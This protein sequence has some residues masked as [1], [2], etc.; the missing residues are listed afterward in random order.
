IMLGMRSAPEP[1]NNLT[2]DNKTTQ[3]EDKSTAAPTTESQKQKTN[4]D[5]LP[6][7]TEPSVPVK[8]KPL[9]PP[10]VDNVD[11]AWIDLKKHVDP[12]KHRVRGFWHV[13]GNALVS[14]EESST[15]LQLPFEPGDEYELRLIAERPAAVTTLHLVLPLPGSQVSVAF[16]APGSVTTFEMIDKKL[17]INNLTT[18][19]KS[20]MPPGQPCQIFCK[21]RKESIKISVGDTDIIHWQDNFARLSVPTSMWTPNPRAIAVGSSR[22]AIRFTAL[23]VKPLTGPGTMLHGMPDENGDNSTKQKA[24]KER[25]AGTEWLNSKNE[26]F[27]WDGNGKFFHKGVSRG[28]QTIGDKA[29]RLIHD[30]K[31]AEYD[32]LRFDRELTKFQQTNKTG[33]VITNIADGVRLP[34]GDWLD[35]RII[36]TVEGKD[37]L[38]FKQ[39]T[40]RWESIAGKPPAKIKINGTELTWPKTYSIRFPATHAL[41]GKPMDFSKVKFAKIRGKGNVSLEAGSDF[42]ALTFDNLQQTSPELIEISLNLRLGDKPT[43]PISEIGRLI[44]HTDFIND[45]AVS[46]GGQHVASTSK[47]NSVRFWRLDLSKEVWRIQSL[48][49]AMPQAIQFINSKEIIYGSSENKLLIAS[50]ETAKVGLNW[51]ILSPPGDCMLPVAGGRRLLFSTERKVYS[52][53]LQPEIKE[54]KSMA[55]ALFELHKDSKKHAWIVAFSENGERA[56]STGEDETIRIWDTQ[57][58]KELFRLKKTTIAKTGL[59]SPAGDLLATADR[60]SP[61]ADLWDAASGRALRRSAFFVSGSLGALAFSPDGKRLVSGH[62][63]G[64]IRVWNVADLSEI[65]RIK[66]QYGGVRQIRF[67]PDGK[68]IITTSSDKTIRVWSLPD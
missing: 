53:D 3:R 55:K 62:G 65:A 33:K 44:G 52:L 49:D 38:Q 48:T 41:F 7:T 46:P 22:G 26:M 32:E 17:S 36:A 11:I 28:A 21:I 6:P 66:T 18:F 68:R 9:P 34:P 56:L 59:F 16:E 47:D 29:V 14:D 4:S 57:A 1:T 54:G 51:S 5:K 20:V 58:K 37:V 35:V 42:L 24:F 8:S 27:A 60:N 31:G 40:M 15:R 43:N 64:G 19:K 61:T 2:A 25:L 12:E 39:D 50:V 63:D 10:P 67:L 23:E 45:I 30:D 13:D